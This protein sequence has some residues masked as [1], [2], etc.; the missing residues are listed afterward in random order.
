ML[1]TRWIHHLKA[2]SVAGCVLL[3]GGAAG[4]LFVVNQRG[5]E[6][7]WS[8]RIAAE[9]ARR[10]IHA[11][12][13]SV[14]FSPMRG[15]IAR[16]VVFYSGGSPPHEFARIPRLRFEVDRGKALR[17]ELQIRR[18]LMHE[19]ELFIPITSDGARTLKVADLKGRARLDSQNRLVLEEARGTLGDMDFSLEVELDEFQFS[20]VSGT[21]EPGDHERR[22]EFVEGVLQEL[23]HWSV[24]ASLP[25]SRRPEIAVR[26]TGNAQR[27]SS[28]RTSFTVKADEVV[29]HEYSMK[30]ALLTGTLA[31]RS[32]TVDHL[33]FSDASGRLALSAHYDLE[34]KT[35]H[36]EGSS[37]IKI[38]DLLRKGLDNH[39]IDDIVSI[40]APRIEARGRFA[41]TD[42][43]LRL[44][45]IGD[46]E[47][48]SLNLL[49]ILLRDLKTEFSWQNG[50]IFL[51]ELGVTHAGKALTGQILM[52]RD[53]IRFQAVSRLPLS[54]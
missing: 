23:A 15:I 20:D 14:R 44:G 41:L 10:G 11:K 31:G 40:H 33:E 12:F 51:R 27:L 49:G 4:G 24:P 3:V 6:G 9:L 26:V 2:A 25:A 17:G 34:D 52:N 22:D 46:L 32:L 37:S 36:Y 35:G 29:R 28:I 43:G 18:V 54:A 16:D 13:E 48:Q 38:T 19:A 1:K 42:S 30:S 39:S 21:A 8:E 47:W 7:E 53:T 5:F 50:D 45:V